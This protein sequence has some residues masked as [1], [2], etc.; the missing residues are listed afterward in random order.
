MNEQ[1]VIQRRGAAML[2]A[3]AVLVISMTLA[4]TIASVT[5][6][7]QLTR[8]VNVDR[9]NA[10]W[11]LASAER[12]IDHW[13]THKAASV[14]LPTDVTGPSVAITHDII[15][16]DENTSAEILIT[17]WDQLGM[18]PMSHV[19]SGSPLRTLVPSEFLSTLDAAMDGDDEKI[20]LD[21]FIQSDEQHVIPVRVFPEALP[22]ATVVFGAD[23]QASARVQTT[24]TQD[25]HVMGAFI[26]THPGGEA[27]AINVNTAPVSL[28]EHALRMAGRSGI[29][30]IVHARMEGKPAPI[31]DLLVLETDGADDSRIRLAG[32][33]RCWAFRVDL[34]VNRVQRSWWL[35][36][37]RRG[38]SKWRCVQR[39]LIT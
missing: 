28:V 38:R 19:V 22:G 6:R 3:L 14:V 39:L 8:E 30:L 32:E 21:L 27:P 10:D 9:S 13:L 17:A 35:V 25:L 33:S 24:R 29:D 23:R 4:A 36:Y 31:A 7:D 37:E 16:I 18:I 2:L 5:S 11:L 26:A 15:V 20:G 1:R 12:R 34:R